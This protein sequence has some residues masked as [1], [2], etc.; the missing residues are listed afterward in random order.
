MK[1][2]FSIIMISMLMVTSLFSAAAFAT[3]NSANTNQNQ[4]NG[5]NKQVPQDMKNHVF[6]KITA[7]SENSVTISVVEMKKPENTDGQKFD[8]RPENNENG[9]NQQKPT[10]EQLAEMKKNFENMFTATGETKT[11]DI[12]NAKFGR[13]RRKPK[14]NNSANNSTT[15]EEKTKTYKDYAVGDY[16]AIE[17]SGEN[18][19]VAKEVSDIGRMPGGPRGFGKDG[20]GNN[21]N[22]GNGWNKNNKG[23]NN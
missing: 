14:D 23:N 7:I 4:Q 18:T 6:G 2:I 1:K 21:G 8:A 3:G 22:K 12:S 16:V 11:I 20:N 13:E 19:N 10:E 15:T 5:W 9:N 17:L